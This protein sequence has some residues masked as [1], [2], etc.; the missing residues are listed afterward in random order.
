MASSVDFFVEF[1]LCSTAA[2][3]ALD[4][5]YMVVYCSTAAALFRANER[6][7]PRCDLVTVALWEQFILLRDHTRCLPR[8]PVSWSLNRHR[9]DRA[10]VDRTPAMLQ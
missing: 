6:P 10:I 3:G 7:A 1:V 4:W 9:G 5:Y 2:V 8:S